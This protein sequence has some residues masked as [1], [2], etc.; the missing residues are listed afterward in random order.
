MPARAFIVHLC[1]NRWNSAIAEYVVSAGYALGEIPQHFIVLAGSPLASRIREAGF[2]LTEVKNFRF[3]QAPLLYR[4][5]R[6]KKATTVLTYGGQETTLCR[7]IKWKFPLRIIRFFGDAA[8]LE[9][10]RKFHLNA[11]IDKLIVPSR[12]LAAYFRRLY[13]MR[14]VH[15][16]TLGCDDKKFYFSAAE[17][18][19]VEHPRLL[20][21]GRF[22]PVKGHVHALRVFKKL[23]DK[24]PEGALRPQLWIVGLPANLGADDLRRAVEE[25]SL[26]L[27]KDV[28]VRSERVAD[29]A[30][31]MRSVHV[32]WVS[33]IG[34]EVICRVAEEFLLCG[35][36]VFVSGV[37]SLDECLFSKEAGDSYRYPTLDDNA[38]AAMLK[39]V[40]DEAFQE[41][42]AVRKERAETA[43]SLFGFAAM[44]CALKGILE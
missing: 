37:G 39:R 2:S 15:A 11:A 30:A 40:L 21:F 7:L 14:A 10:R 9:R 12:H 26:T 24:Y 27:D 43:R 28:V 17:G 8:R 29:V 33:S 13:P 20:I 32:G 34:S 1:S 16:V 35:T 25:L 4:L 19:T 44:S 22:D 5:L 3:T 23:L 6:A 41:T 42:T 18:R 36:R 38:I 31:L